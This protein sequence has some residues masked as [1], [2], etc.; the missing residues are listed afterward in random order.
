VGIPNESFFLETAQ[1][2]RKTPVSAFITR[3]S[4]PGKGV[5]L[6][7]KLRPLLLFFGKVSIFKV[8]GEVKTN[9]SVIF[10]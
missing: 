9:N 6:K 3:Q 1:S 4:L 8:A 2:Q 7:K 10:I 5:H